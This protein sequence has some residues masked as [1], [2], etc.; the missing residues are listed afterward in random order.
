MK[1]FKKNLVMDQK[2]I[3]AFMENKKK[4]KKKK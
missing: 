3:F 4:K 1:I 2:T